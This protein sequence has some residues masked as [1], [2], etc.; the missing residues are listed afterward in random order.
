MQFKIKN[1]DFKISFSFFAL[2]LLALASDEGKTVFLFMIFAVLHE[3]VHLIFIYLLSVPPQS[4]SLSLLGASIRRGAG[5]ATST[6]S[7]ILINL[8]APVFNIATG[9][10]FLL[11]SK[12]AEE[13]SSLFTEMSTVNLILGGFNL[14]PFYTFD[15]GNA[16]RCILTRLFSQRITENIETAISLIITVVF[17]FI[18]IHIFLN[19]SHNFSLLI[20]CIYMFLSIIFKKQNSLDY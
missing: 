18:S 8:S 15:G 3:C 7:E 9:A 16:L 17:S 20:M 10:F 19:Y 12:E 4:V 1:T 5:G 11:F 13:Y 6:N 14:I 2:V